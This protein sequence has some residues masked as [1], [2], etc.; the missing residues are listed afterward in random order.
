MPFKGTSESYLHRR[1][2]RSSSDGQENRLQQ[3]KL[4]ESVLCIGGYL[5]VELLGRAQR[6]DIDNL[7]Y[8]C[9]NCVEVRAATQ[10]CLWR[11]QHPTAWRLC[12]QVL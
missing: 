8:I 4:P 6:C 10:S 3:F 5:Q 11:T 1:I 2:N 12:A 7:F 9:I